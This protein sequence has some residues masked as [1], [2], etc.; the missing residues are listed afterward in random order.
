MSER[1]HINLKTKLAAALCQL[2]RYDEEQACFVRIIPHEEAKKLSEEEILAR[3]DFHHDP[4][5]KAHDGPDVHW[6][7]T[8]LPKA[9]HKHITDTIDIPRIAKSKRIQKRN[10]GIRKPRTITRWRKF[11]REPVYASRDR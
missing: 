6:N 11:N 8:P 9:E 10:A 3:F 4:I 2:V 1:A 5:P 7:L